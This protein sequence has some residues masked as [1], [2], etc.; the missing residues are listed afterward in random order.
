MDFLSSADRSRLM[1]RIK[2]KDTKPE[3]TVRRLVYGLGFRYRLH[4]KSLP[5]RPDLTFA[6]RR[7]VIFVHGCFW[8]QHSGCSIGRLPKTR[9]DYWLPK[10]ERNTMRDRLNK[11]KLA[12]EGWDVLIVWEC[13]TRCLE[14]LTAQIEQFLRPAG[15]S[16][17]A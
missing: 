5:G 1:S 11:I 6:S 15:P 8:H 17:T 2:S 10:L 3:L 7:K 14:T 12:E 13:E 4:I 9:Q 16:P